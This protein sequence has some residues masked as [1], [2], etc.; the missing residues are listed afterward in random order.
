MPVKDE[1]PAIFGE[2]EKFKMTKFQNKEEKEAWVKK[3]KARIKL[4]EEKEEAYSIDKESDE[5][6]ETFKRIDKNKTKE[7]LKEESDEFME[8]ASNMVQKHAD[9]HN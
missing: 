2:E 3:I 4:G 1:Y 6:K 7:Q 8:Y 5:L 9:K